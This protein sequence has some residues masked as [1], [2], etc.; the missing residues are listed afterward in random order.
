MKKKTQVFPRE[1]KRAR[2]WV[3]STGQRG[4]KQGINF[5][6]TTKKA[7]MEEGRKKQTAPSK[8]EGWGGP[9]DLKKSHRKG[10]GGGG[11]KSSGRLGSES[12]REK[13]PGELKKD[14][15]Q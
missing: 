5:K 10:N 13:R 2:G 8:R 11:G 4:E 12:T 15:V 7:G 9:S 1:E 14:S 6:G 3:R